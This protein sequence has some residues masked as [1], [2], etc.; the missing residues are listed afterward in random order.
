MTVAASRRL[1]GPLC[2][3][4]LVCGDLFVFSIDFEANVI[5]RLSQD[6]AIAWCISYYEF[7]TRLFNLMEDAPCLTSR[8]YARLRARTKSCRLECD[9][10]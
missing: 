7:I 1:V 5:A 10:C 2:M 4:Y 9:A 3:N 6:R 8:L